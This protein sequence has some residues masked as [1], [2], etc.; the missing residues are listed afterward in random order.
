MQLRQGTSECLA[1]REHGLEQVTVPFDPLQRLAHPEAA[2]RHVL[3]Q[4]VPAKRRRDRRTRLRPHRVDRGD[5]L[6]PRVLTVVDE[7]ALALALQPFGRDQ[8]GC[9]SSSS[10]RHALARTCRSARRSRGAQSGRARGSRPRRSVYDVEL[11]APA[12]ELLADQVSDADRERE[13]AVGRVE[14]EEHEVRAVRL[15]DA[16]VPSVHVDAVH[17]HHPEQRLRRVDEREVDEPRL[18]LARVGAEGARRDPRGHP[19][20]RLLLEVRIP[21]TP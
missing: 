9:R 20:R 3:C 12:A 1:A 13:A 19:L 18:A 17:L 15:V 5:G 2:R 6:P 8:P 4:L 14:V 21:P 10:P 7:H 11:E 16:R